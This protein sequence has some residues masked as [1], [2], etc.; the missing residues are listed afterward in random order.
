M[1]N[2]VHTSVSPKPRP[3]PNSGPKLSINRSEWTS[4]TVDNDRS[5]KR[6]SLDPSGSVSKRKKT[7]SSC[8]TTSNEELPQRS[9]SDKEEMNENDLVYKRNFGGAREDRPEDKDVK[10]VYRKFGKLR[11]SQFGKVVRKSL[12]LENIFYSVNA[13]FSPAF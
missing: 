8:L 6:Q 2:T 12:P 7:P 1:N 3:T 10:V 9:D 11:T 4:S 13:F 5:A